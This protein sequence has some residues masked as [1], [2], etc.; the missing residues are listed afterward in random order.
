MRFIIIG[1][2]IQKLIN[3]A[4]PRLNVV[5]KYCFSCFKVLPLLILRDNFE[6]SQIKI[7]N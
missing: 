3:S 5:Q 1:A 4:N 7:D 6:S 2:V